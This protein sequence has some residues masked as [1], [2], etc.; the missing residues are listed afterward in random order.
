MQ[1][2]KTQKRFAIWHR[3]LGLIASIGVLFLAITGI[4]LNHIDYWD[5]LQQPLPA[6]LLS[7]FYGVPSDSPAIVNFHWERLL[8]DLHAGRFFAG[9]Q[10][11]L[12]NGF[13]LA[14]IFLACS[15]I[16]LYSKGRNTPK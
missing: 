4:I 9:A 16:Y 10:H 7:F 8:L 11:F 2:D 14:M 5:W 15:G 6:G 3:R 12:M 1:S 13:A